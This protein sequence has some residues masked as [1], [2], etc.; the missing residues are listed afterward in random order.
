MGHPYSDHIQKFVTGKTI[1]GIRQDAMANVWIIFTNGEKIQIYHN[2]LAKHPDLSMICTPYQAD[3][4]I[5]Q[6]L[7]IM[8]GK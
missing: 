5:K 6:S 7:D 4:T 2:K 3:G 8:A 1:T